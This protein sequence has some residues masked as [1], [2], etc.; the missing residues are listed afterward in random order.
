MNASTARRK[1]VVFRVDSNTEIGV[2]H[3]MRCA[4]LAAELARRDFA[5]TIASRSMIPWVAD[6][7]SQIGARAIALSPGDPIDLDHVDIAIFDGYQLGIELRDAAET[8][9]PVVVIDDNMELPVG[10]TDLVVNQNIHA[11][12]VRYPTDTET[13]FLLGCSYA[14]IRDDVRGIARRTEASAN[15]SVL[16]AIGGTDPF[17]LTLP[18]V[19]GLLAN[20][21]SEIWA[22][23]GTE[24][25]DRQAFDQLS[26]AN[27]DTVKL[28]PRDLIGPLTVIDVATIGAGST[29]WEAAFLGI[30]TVS[31]IIADNQLA[32]SREA[33]RIGIT[34]A[35]D[36]R[37]HADPDSVAAEA[38]RL[39]LD[40]STRSL[41]S[42]AGSQTIDGRGH[43]R[44]ADAIERLLT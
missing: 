7:Y 2:G 38:R 22:A 31:L 34:S 28:A 25:P 19:R 39:M 9:T 33:A 41:M 36:Q 4:T 16:V 20:H 32:A 30:P 24:H 21:F 3:A 8:Q 12:S 5:V 40:E 14:L 23:I 6:R 26:A 44:I 35:L 15:G 37:H 27:P 29:M 42:R 43:E 10:I 17:R 18:L 1:H 13:R 11:H